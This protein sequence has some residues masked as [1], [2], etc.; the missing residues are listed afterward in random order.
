MSGYYNYSMSNN[1]VVAYDEGK[2]PRSKW[3]KGSLI[4]ALSEIYDN[5]TASDLK[6]FSAQ[7]LRRVFLQRTEWHHT[8]SYYNETDFYEVYDGFKP[9]HALELCEETKKEIDCEREEKKHSSKCSNMALCKY[10][11]WGG[12]RNH[13]K[14]VEK[15]GYCWI[16]SNNN[17]AYFDGFKKSTSARG[18]LIVKTFD[19]APRGSSSEFKKIKK[20]LEK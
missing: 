6:K 2:K 7:V 10:L 16:D 11:E 19:R 12:S 8:S 3:D 20:A 18:F 14:A 1:A 4:S 9:C 17:W 5:E 13:P 15:E